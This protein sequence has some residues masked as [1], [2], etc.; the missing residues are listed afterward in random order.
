MALVTPFAASAARAL[1]ASGVAWLLSA[2]CAGCTVN[3]RPLVGPDPRQYFENAAHTGRSVMIDALGINL[4]TVDG[5]TGL[6]LGR[7]RRTYYF[8]GRDSG[9][10]GEQGGEHL[11][12]GAPELQLTRIGQPDWPA[13]RPLVIRGR[14]DGVSIGLD[15]ARAGVTLGVQSFSALRLPAD[16]NLLLLIKSDR[17]APGRD[18]FHVKETRP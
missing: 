2:A 13:E 3:G 10:A 6:T 15:K 7:I 12:G 11:S 4:S 1:I 16:S 17:A 18:V 14:T 5:D 9:G 8:A